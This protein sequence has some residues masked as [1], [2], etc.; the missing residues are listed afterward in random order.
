[1]HKTSIVL[2]IWL[3]SLG[4]GR[5]PVAPDGPEL[6]FINATEEQ[7]QI[8]LNWWEKQK[9]CV[10]YDGSKTN[11]FPVRVVPG[12]FLCGTVMAAGCTRS[13]GIVV[14]AP[15]F[16]MAVAHEYIHHYDFVRDRPDPGHTGPLWAKCDPNYNTLDPTYSTYFKCPG[17][18]H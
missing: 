11:N 2:A 13:S 6:V 1:M 17:L 14:A 5:S 18:M 10:T 7:A 8:G 4:C 3:T 12:G 16:E 15:W 9:I